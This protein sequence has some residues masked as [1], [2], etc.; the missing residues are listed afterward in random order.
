MRRWRVLPSMVHWSL[1]RTNLPSRAARLDGTP[2]STRASRAD[3]LPDLE[4]PW[5]RR[6][7]RSR[8]DPLAKQPPDHP[9]LSQTDRQG[10]GQD[11]VGSMRIRAAQAC[12]PRA[13]TALPVAHS[14]PVQP[15]TMTAVPAMSARPASSAIDSLNRS[16]EWNWSSGSKSERAIQRKVPAENARAPA[17]SD[18]AELGAIRPPRTQTGRCRRGS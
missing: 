16:W 10:A 15:G 11:Q 7:M 3:G 1:L 18:V 14:R 5:S 6:V 4:V 13:I 8:H 12:K 17:V 9:S 2:G